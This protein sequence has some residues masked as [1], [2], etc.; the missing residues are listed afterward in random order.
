MILVYF[1]HND[2]TLLE[3]ELSV[4]PQY[5][6]LVYIDRYGESIRYITLGRTWVFDKDEHGNDE[7][8]V[9]VELAKR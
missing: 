2:S 9:N 8:Y 5:G 6:D 4:L 3:I 1:V 7:K